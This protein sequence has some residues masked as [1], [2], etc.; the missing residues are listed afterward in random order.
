MKLF[1]FYSLFC[2]NISLHAEMHEFLSWTLF[3]LHVNSRNLAERLLFW[4][5]EKQIFSATSCSFIFLLPQVGPYLWNTSLVLCKYYVYINYFLNSYNVFFFFND[6]HRNFMNKACAAF[7][8]C[9]LHFIYRFNSGLYICIFFYA[10]I[11][12]FILVLLKR[13]K[14]FL[15]S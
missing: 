2:L 4:W 9:D 6:L 3:F 10:F 11:H 13:K 7:I 8:K 12:S 15:I 5:A 1:F 14:T